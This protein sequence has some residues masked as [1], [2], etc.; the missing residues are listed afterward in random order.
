MSRFPTEAPGARMPMLF[1]HLATNLGIG[2]VFGVAFTT[3]LISADVA[4][5]GELIASS[6]DPLLPVLMLGF[7]N[8][9]TF[10]SLAMGTGVMAMPRERHSGQDEGNEPGAPG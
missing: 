3:F 1:R 2:A 10:G 7:M 4:G 6:G 9:L 8:V 5:I